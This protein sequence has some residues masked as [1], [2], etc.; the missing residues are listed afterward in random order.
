MKF[1][2]LLA[3]FSLCVISVP[4]AFAQTGSSF[5]VH[6]MVS[7]GKK[8]KEVKSK[9]AFDSESFALNSNKA[10]VLSKSFNYADITAA[11]YSH[12][13]KPLLSTGG[14]VA[15][16]ILTGLI[17]LPFLF[18]KKKSHWLSVRTDDDY[19]VMKLDGD[20]YRQILAEFEVKNVNVT[21]V[22]EEEKKKGK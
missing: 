22:E 21:T 5:Q 18:M 13:K 16:A 10:G 20:N 1:L 17:V 11:D 7:D 15:M 6:S 19:V 9:L 3:V 14:A 12:S 4:H 2:T 8:S